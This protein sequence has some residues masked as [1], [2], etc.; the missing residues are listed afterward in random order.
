MTKCLDWRISSFLVHWSWWENIA[1]LWEKNERTSGQYSLKKWRTSRHFQVTANNLDIM[2]SLQFRPKW[3]IKY[4]NLKSVK[5][6][7]IRSLWNQR[8]Y[9]QNLMWQNK[10]IV[11][12]HFFFMHL[13]SSKIVVNVQAKYE[14]SLGHVFAENVK[15]VATFPR[16][17]ENPK[18]HL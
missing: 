6:G 2:E 8:T 14:Q 18:L 5:I 13:F 4:A 15:D 1:S 16:N 12:Y 10:Y 9:Q 11:V 7:N 3:C 17:S